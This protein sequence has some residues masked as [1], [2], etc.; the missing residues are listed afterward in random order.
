MRV[1]TVIRVKK[2]SAAQLKVLMDAG[3]KYVVYA[4]DG[5]TLPKRR[6]HLVKK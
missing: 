1:P 6:L 4:D 5:I 2:A 3:V